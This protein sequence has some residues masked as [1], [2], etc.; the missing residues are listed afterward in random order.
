MELVNQSV[1][2]GKKVLVTGHSGFK[3][4]WLM[5]WLQKLGAQTLGIS[6]EPNSPN[7][8]NCLSLKGK[9]V[10]LDINQY[11]ALEKE[12]TD[13]DPHF[14]FHLAAQ[15]LVRYSYKEP[16]ETFHTNVIGTL[17]L[18]EISRKC[19]SLEG[20]LC[21]T[22]DKVYENQELDKG[23]VE[24]DKLGGF[25]PYSASKACAELVIS[26]MR[27]S[28]FNHVSGKKVLIASA[29]GG[30]VVGGGDFSE[31]RLIPDI[32]RSWEGEKEIVIRNPGSVRPWQHV[33]DCLYGYI[34]LAEK[35]LAGDEK[36][37]QAW[38]F[39]PADK[40]IITVKEIVDLA[41]QSGIDLEIVIEPSELHETKMLQLDC[42][43]AQELLGWNPKLDMSNTFTWTFDWYKNWKNGNIISKQQL[44]KYLEM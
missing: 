35:L 5:L 11:D 18:L 17:N 20:V 42:T 8:Y 34:T 27:N 37:A 26:S 39:G 41:K 30:N 12:I 21:V 1:F 6:L 33:L 19:S 23:Y 36:A 44:Q 14:I 43:K 7:H 10:F 38:N 4:S 2:K 24:E 13:F 29:R 22:T 3:G 15:P 25:D 40:E 16:L 31:D 9:S 28:F 32:I